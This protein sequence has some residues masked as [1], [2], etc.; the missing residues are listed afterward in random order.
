MSPKSQQ[1][2]IRIQKKDTNSNLEHE[3][4]LNVDRDDLRVHGGCSCLSQGSLSGSPL[5][6]SSIQSLLPSLVLHF[7]LFLMN[8]LFDLFSSSAPTFN[9]FPWQIPLAVEG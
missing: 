2:N 4:Q 5:S 8:L 6:G 1:F 3:Q 7:D 9:W